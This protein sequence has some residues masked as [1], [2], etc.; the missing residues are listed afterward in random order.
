[1]TSQMVVAKQHCCPGIKTISEK[2]VCKYL[3]ICICIVWSNQ[4]CF[5]VSLG[6]ANTSGRSEQIAAWCNRTE[7]E[8]DA[9]EPR[10]DVYTMRRQAKL[11][12]ASAQKCNIMLWNI[13]AFC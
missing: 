11:Y 13:T 7:G 5:S 8:E 3:G 2:T 9:L 10:N 6:A 1:M 4:L 12:Q